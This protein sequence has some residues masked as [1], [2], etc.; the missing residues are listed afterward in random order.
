VTAGIVLAGGAGSRLG[1]PKATVELHGTTLVARAVAM[2]EAVCADIVVVTRPEI[3]LP[4]L[5]VRV[6]LDR[7]GPDCP[8]N[9]LA[10]GLEA[11]VADDVLVLACDLPAAGPVVGRLVASDLGG[12]AAV[13]IDP[14]GRLQPLCARYRRARTLELAD[15]LLG[16]GEL[17]MLALLDRLDV[18]V[19][20]ATHAELR[21]VNTPADLALL[22][23]SGC[24]SDALDPA[25]VHRDLAMTTF[26]RSWDLIDAAD[27]D[28]E[29]EA[30]LLALA[31]T[32][33]WHWHQVG[34]PENEALADHHVAKALALVGDG[35]LSLRFAQRAMDAAG[36]E[37]WTDWKLVACHE[38]LARA[39]AAV[40]DHSEKDR[41]LRAA[42]ELL[43]GLDDEDT[44]VL[45]PQLAEIPGWPPG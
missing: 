38:G 6:V 36:R 19:V 10:S 44:A 21:N 33:W 23:P 9:A 32:S 24:M 12:D 11:V 30:E 39:Y 14:D 8:L 43:P 35:V 28:E 7:A 17:R 2:L 16:R 42:A 26:N 29:A 25:V 20:A 27:R 15:E 3:A 1:R 5:G 40:G 18:A 4:P 13:A 22:L 37:H 41:H 45:Q 34:T 31:F